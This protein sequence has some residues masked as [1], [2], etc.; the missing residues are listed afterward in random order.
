MNPSTP[1]LFAFPTPNE[2]MSELSPLLFWVF[3]IAFCVLVVR[4]W[5]D[6]KQQ[7]KDHLDQVEASRKGR[8]RLHKL[9]A[10]ARAFNDKHR[11]GSQVRYWAAG[12]VTFND[13]TGPRGPREGE[14]ILS[15]TTSEATLIG[16]HAVVAVEGRECW[17]A[18][19]HVQV[20]PD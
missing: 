1:S 2:L 4:H 3:V 15:R 19:T 5:W 9:Q 14:G 10:E 13:Y 20:I 17:I 11:V 16:H 18:L 12:W 6:E 7:K 8:E